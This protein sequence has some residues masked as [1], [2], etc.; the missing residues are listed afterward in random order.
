MN[1]PTESWGPHPSSDSEKKLN[2]SLCVYV[3][4]KQPRKRKFSVV[5]IQVVKRSELHVRNVL[6]FIYRYL[7]GSF[8][9]TFSLPLLSPLPQ[10]LPSPVRRCSQDLSMCV[11]GYESEHV[12]GKNICHFFTRYVCHSRFGP[13]V[14]YFV[15]LETD[16]WVERKK[17][18]LCLRKKM[19]FQRNKQS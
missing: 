12:F 13:L 1:F 10:P 18:V 6:F 4:A 15:C 8:P 16:I 5:F 19:I 14:N 11:N 3:V 9:L 17:T 2:L 7:L